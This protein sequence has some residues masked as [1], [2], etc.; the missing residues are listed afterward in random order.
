MFDGDIITYVL[1]GLIFLL[2]I[3]AIWGSVLWVWLMTGPLMAKIIWTV[4]MA[5]LTLILI[6]MSLVVT[7]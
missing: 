2:L 3:I 6:A 5:A 4:A 7:D 1:M